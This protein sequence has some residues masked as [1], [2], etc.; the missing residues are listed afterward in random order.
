MVAFTPSVEDMRVYH[1]SGQALKLS[2]GRT[3]LLNDLLLMKLRVRKLELENPDDEAAGL[4]LD[5]VPEL[6]M[7]I[8]KYEGEDT[9]VLCLAH[10]R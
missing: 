6:Y 4:D 9:I 1:P 3:I 10:E 2:R 7:G 5:T 8:E